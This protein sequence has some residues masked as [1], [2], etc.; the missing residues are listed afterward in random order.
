[1]G[2]AMGNERESG[3]RAAMIQITEKDNI[4]L[5]PSSHAKMPGISSTEKSHPSVFTHLLREGITK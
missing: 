4:W 3:M 5:L 2:R 1:M